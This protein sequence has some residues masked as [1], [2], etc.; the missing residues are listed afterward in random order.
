MCPNGCSWQG[1]LQKIALHLDLENKTVTKPGGS[2]L[3]ACP[4]QHIACIYKSI[5]CTAKLQRK[6]MDQHMADAQHEHLKLTMTLVAQMQLKTTQLEETVR[7]QTA[8]LAEH[9]NRMR[10]SERMIVFLRQAIG[11]API[12]V[13]VD[14]IPQL[15]DVSEK[16]YSAPFHTH[17]HGYR[18]QISIQ[19]GKEY[20]GYSVY[21]H[22]L[23]GDYDD[24]LEWPFRGE[25]KIE[26][27]SNEGQIVSEVNHVFSELLGKRVKEYG[28]KG[29]GEYIGDL[30][31]TDGDDPNSH[32]LISENC[33]F[34]VSFT[35]Q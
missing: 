15:N 5:G 35:L 2:G 32:C 31:L 28:V 34:R 1:E 8:K 21:A 29:E 23:R 4:L 10:D 18:M 20:S 13:E 27:L 22:L 11:V 14:N 9:E 7:K 3:F 17:F 30:Y 19:F 12:I 25:L 26:I 33:S 6:D 24:T 16:W